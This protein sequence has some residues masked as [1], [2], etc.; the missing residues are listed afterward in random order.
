MSPAIGVHIFDRLGAMTAHGPT[1]GAENP[2]AIEPP[3]IDLQ[4]FSLLSPYDLK[5]GTA[6]AI[7]LNGMAE[8][9][10][11]EKARLD[12]LYAF[13]NAVVSAHGLARPTERAVEAVRRS[14]IV[15]LEH[16]L[17]ARPC[18]MLVQVV[19][20]F[21]VT[22]E[23]EVNGEKASGK[24]I[25]GLMSLAAGFGS[26]ITFTIAGQNAFQAMAGVERLFATHFGAKTALRGFARS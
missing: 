19:Q 25:L 13:M 14:F 23:V 1:R 7:N 4:W 21:L 18:A 10:Q 20:P 15:R 24:S 12:Y 9:G 11:T 2:A 17:H 6:L 26:K 16:G 8:S 5:P 3:R 22:V